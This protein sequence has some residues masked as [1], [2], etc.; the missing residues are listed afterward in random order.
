MTLGFRIAMNTRQ[1]FC[2][3]VVSLVCSASSRGQPKEEKRLRRPHVVFVLADDL[4]YNDI[5]YHA[6]NYGSQ[7]Y[8]P[9]L[10]SLAGV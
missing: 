4:G 7:M 3:V 6:R 8:T 2:F 10:D 9:F 1:L 5:G